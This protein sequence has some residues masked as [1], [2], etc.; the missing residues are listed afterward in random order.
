MSRLHSAG[1]ILWG[2]Q[3]PIITTQWLSARDHVKSHAQQKRIKA[4][5]LGHLLNRAK[6]ARTLHYTRYEHNALMAVFE[7][8]AW[9]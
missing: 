4:L 9:L 8:T 2:T 6:N 3:A 5:P 7:A 1:V